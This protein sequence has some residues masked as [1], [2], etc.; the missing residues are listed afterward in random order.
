MASP[1]GKIDPALSVPPHSTNGFCYGRL[2]RTEAATPQLGGHPC[3]NSGNFAMFAAIRR[4]SFPSRRPPQLRGHR[5][6]QTCDTDPERGCPSALN[7]WIG[8]V[9]ARPR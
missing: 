4:A 7:L 3:N 6:L 5:L 8:R 1:A 2:G 9:Q